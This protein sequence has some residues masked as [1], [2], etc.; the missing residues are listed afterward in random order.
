MLPCKLQPLFID[1]GLFTMFAWRLHERSILQIA[2]SI[3]TIVNR[4]DIDLRCY[5]YTPKGLATQNLIVYC[6]ACWSP[7]PSQLSGSHVV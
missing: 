2:Y 7:K 1:L 6:A 3:F 4:A 5:Q